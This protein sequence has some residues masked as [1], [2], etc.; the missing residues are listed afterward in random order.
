MRTSGKS[1][2]EGCHQRGRTTAEGERRLKSVSLCM[3]LSL[4]ICLSLCACVCSSGGAGIR[5]VKCY[6][7]PSPLRISRD[8]VADVKT[9]QCLAHRGDDAYEEHTWIAR[10]HPAIFRPR[11]MRNFFKKYRTHKDAICPGCQTACGHSFANQVLFP[12]ESFAF[13]RLR[14]VLD[15]AVRR[16]VFSGVSRFPLP[17]I[18]ALLRS[19]LASPK[20][21]HSTR[22]VFGVTLSR[23]ELEGDSVYIGRGL[24][25]SAAP[26]WRRDA[27]YAAGS[28]AP[29][30]IAVVSVPGTPPLLTSGSVGLSVVGPARASSS[31]RQSRRRAFRRPSSHGDIH[32]PLLCYLLNELSCSLPSCSPT[33]LKETVS[34]CTHGIGCGQSCAVIGSRRTVVRRYDLAGHRPR[35]PE[36]IFVPSARRMSTPS[37]SLSGRR[38][39]L[40]RRNEAITRLFPVSALGCSVIVCPWRHRTAIQETY[41]QP[42][43]L[44]LRRKGGKLIHNG[45]FPQFPKN[46]I[47]STGVNF[48]ERVCFPKAHEGRRGGR[49]TGDDVVIR[50][51]RRTSSSLRHFVGRLATYSSGV[52]PSFS[53]GSYIVSLGLRQS[54]R[55]TLSFC[56]VLIIYACMP[57]KIPLLV[58]I[59]FLARVRKII[60]LPGKVIS[61]LKSNNARLDDTN[62]DKRRLEV[63]VDEYWLGNTRPQATKL[64]TSLPLVTASLL[65]LGSQPLM[66][67]STSTS[68]SARR[69]AAVF[70][71]L[72]VTS[73]RFSAPRVAPRVRGR[74]NRA[75]FRYLRKAIQ[76]ESA[77]RICNSKPVIS[78]HPS[79]LSSTTL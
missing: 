56:S 8:G 42:S 50:N 70:I 9:S 10:S 79:L 40:Y 32:S 61:P 24:R 44:F 13:S 5:R 29:R 3:S 71:E 16:W 2:A 35:T 21:L 20:P 59:I 51:S 60:S 77:V 55:H 66:H 78:F 57:V 17:F 26:F 65:S 73:G 64:Q 53:A 36:D 34:Y 37:P 1:G 14:I 46:K 4:C 18:P 11:D 33:R 38:C 6:C 25:P 54:S 52:I 49:D 72:A 19:R 39:K 45:M 68:L 7:A 75:F 43:L 69:P 47:P 15:D 28:D 62:R 23:G 30:P 58:T 67:S 48:L 76:P 31:S 27:P 22:A 74:Q 12:A 41:G 63:A